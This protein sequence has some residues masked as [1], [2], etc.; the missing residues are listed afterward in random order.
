MPEITQ[1][2]NTNNNSQSEQQKKSP[3]PKPIVPKKQKE[4]FDEKN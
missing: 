2:N 4:M 1:N 3:L